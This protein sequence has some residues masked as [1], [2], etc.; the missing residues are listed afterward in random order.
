M[1]KFTKPEKHFFN[2]CCRFVDRN[3][4]D[5]W[6]SG[7]IWE[8]DELSAHEAIKKLFEPPKFS[9]S[10]LDIQI[11][12]LTTAGE[13]VVGSSKRSSKPKVNHKKKA[14]KLSDVNLL[15]IGAFEPALIPFIPERSIT[16]PDF[17]VVFPK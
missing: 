13:P 1:V 15:E 9:A 2:W 17:Y 6:E 8:L 7:T 16:E 10:I 4:V 5:T 3:G 12:E 11:Y 14:V